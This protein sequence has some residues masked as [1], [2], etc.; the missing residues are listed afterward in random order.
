MYSIQ[1]VCMLVNSKAC[2]LSSQQKILEFGHVP[3][4]DEVGGSWGTEIA[5]TIGEKEKRVSIGS[6]TTEF[7]ITSFVETIRVLVNADF[8]TTVTR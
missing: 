1:M 2:R 4:V 3:R 5:P 8:H 6:E 7:E